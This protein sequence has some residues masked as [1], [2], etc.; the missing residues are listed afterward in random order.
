MNPYS[1]LTLSAAADYSCRSVMQHAAHAERVLSLDPK[2]AEEEL[3]HQQILRNAVVGMVVSV[4]TFTFARVAS[5]VQREVDQLNSVL[6]TKLYE[7]ISKN[8]D[9][10]WDSIRGASLELLGINLSSVSLW[11]HMM[12]YVEVRNSAVHANGLLTRRQVNDSKIPPMLKLIDV[13]NKQQRLLLRQV[14][15]LAAAKVS[16]TFIVEVDALTWAVGKEPDA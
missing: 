2:L 16:R 15:V 4:E 14:N 10:S 1:S 8:I 7:R 11:R 6:T 9:K 5:C 3:D 12:A 13:T